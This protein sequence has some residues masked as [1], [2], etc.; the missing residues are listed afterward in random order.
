MK[1]H[2]EYIKLIKVAKTVSTASA[3]QV[4]YLWAR[5]LGGEA[6]VKLLKKLGLLDEA[7]DFAVET[8]EFA[9]AFE[10]SKFAE[11]YKN[12]EIHLKYAMFLEDEGKFQQARDEFILAG[13]AKEAILMYI[14]NEDWTNA[15]QV[16]EKYEESSVVDVLIGQAKVCFQKKE[17]SKAESLIL[18]AQKPELAIRFYQDE[19]NWNEALRFAKQYLPIKSSQVQADYEKYLSGQSN[20]GKEH[21]LRL[22]KQFEENHE[23]LR[24]IDMY[25]KLN[26]THTESHDELV[27]AWDKAAALCAKYAPNDKRVVSDKCAKLLEGIGRYDEAAD[28]YISNQMYKESADVFISAGLWE[29]ARNMV[30]YAPNLKDYVDSKCNGRTRVGHLTEK[31]ESSVSLHEFAKRGEWEKCIEF[32]AMENVMDFQLEE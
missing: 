28:I 10:L 6:A 1:R 2:I 18:R 12:E 29:K 30:K 17:Y 27:M 26:L 14:H 13:K 21:I 11:K 31:S 16:A 24:A 22:A 32:A 20:S 4:A 23:F 19:N 15:L 7:L 25:L 9:F 8:A 3:K 5:S